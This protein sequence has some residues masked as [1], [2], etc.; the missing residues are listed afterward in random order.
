MT[1]TT[2]GTW[3]ATSDAMFGA[4]AAPTTRVGGRF[5]KSSRSGEPLGLGFKFS[6]TG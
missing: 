4:I 6:S 2:D 1:D 5:V 3:G